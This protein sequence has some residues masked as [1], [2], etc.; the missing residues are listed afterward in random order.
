[1][2]EL[3]KEKFVF[4]KKFFMV[5]G[6]IATVFILLLIILF[7]ALIIIKP[8]GIDVTN[9]LK[10]ST[11]DSYDHPYLTTQQENILKSIGVDSKDIP[12]E[13][14]PAQ[15]KCAVE[16]LGVQRVNEIKAGSTPTLTEILNIK[17][18]LD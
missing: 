16:L 11:S 15:E 14:T 10:E 8:Y 1:M 5:I 4:L 17:S 7:V 12:T 3:K 2:S 18:C 9:L 6:I 13:I